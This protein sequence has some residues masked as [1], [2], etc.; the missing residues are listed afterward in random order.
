MSQNDSNC[1]IVSICVGF[2]FHVSCENFKAPPHLERKP[3]HGC[4]HST[5]WA[6]RIYTVGEFQTNHELCWKWTSR[7]WTVTPVFFTFWS[8]FSSLCSSSVDVSWDEVWMK[9]E[10]SLTGGPFRDVDLHEIP[11][12]PNRLV[13]RQET[14]NQRRLLDAPAQVSRWCVDGRMI[15]YASMQI[16][17]K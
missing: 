5:V 10:R 2:A 6:P 12:R 16:A 4:C 14:A 3:G 9:P 13:E 17:W 1:P 11:A 15:L 8:R 7:L